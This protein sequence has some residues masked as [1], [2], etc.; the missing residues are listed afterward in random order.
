MKVRDTA[1]N[2]DVLRRPRAGGQSTDDRAKDRKIE[3][4]GGNNSNSGNWR[5]R[6]SDERKV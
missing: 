1:K 3:Q 2:Q 4:M 6:N 5:Q